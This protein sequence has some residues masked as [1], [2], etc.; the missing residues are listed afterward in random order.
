[1]LNRI[2]GEFRECELSVVM[3]PSGS[4]KSTLLNVIS[5]F[6]VKNASGSIR[7]NGI[8]S[9]NS[10]RLIRR[11]SAYIM[12]N[13]TLYPLLNVRESMEFAIK[14]KTGYQMSKAQQND[15]ID[16]I[17]KQL[18]LHGTLD[19]LAK[20]LSGGQQKR[21]SIAI[22]L[23]DDPK[24]LFL[25]EPTTGLDSLSAT[26]CV[27]LL[28]KLAEEGRTIICT[29][30][31]PSA[32]LFEQFDHLYV[33]AEGNCIYQGSS[34]N[35]VPFLSGLG[36]VCPEFYNPADYLLE[37][38]NNDY[39]LHNQRLADKIQNG[40]NDDY[41]ASPQ[42]TL[43]TDRRP[44]ASASSSQPATFSYQLYLLILRNF[45]FM[46]RDKSFMTLRLAVSLVMALFVGTLFY[47]IGH[48]ASHVFDNF[49]YV[50]VTTHFM[51]YGAF[52]SLMVRGNLLLQSSYCRL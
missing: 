22:E 52:F 33:L 51:T 47:N 7:Y 45:I 21:L 1:M 50:Y 46:Q 27:T 9:E 36:L 4:G 2:N 35:V 40:L 49:K 28:K 30:H 19:T 11:Q 17:L 23:V 15:K 42:T 13:Q 20:N 39:G 5:G 48:L 8:D 26:Q 44:I 16:S 3:G 14:L 31:T 41:R 29:I 37:I 6:V 10:L 34:G 38:S 32:R 12:Q 43:Q 24:V 25:D 18:G